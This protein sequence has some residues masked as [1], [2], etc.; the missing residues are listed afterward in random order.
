MPACPYFTHFRK[1]SFPPQVFACQRHKQ[2]PAI[3]LA[4]PE[5]IPLTYPPEI[6]EDNAMSIRNIVQCVFSSTA[7]KLLFKGWVASLPVYC[8]YSELATHPII[9]GWSSGLRRRAHNP[10]IAG[11]NPAPAIGYG[12][13]SFFSPP[14][15]SS[16]AN[17]CSAFI[18]F[19]SPSEAGL[20]RRSSFYL[21]IDLW[22]I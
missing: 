21:R 12:Q 11:S 2:H 9:A 13:M 14:K 8:V 3:F 20:L 18:C 16:K 17:S 7:R 22:N 15:P 19:S 10:E 1:K 5:I 4:I 6:A